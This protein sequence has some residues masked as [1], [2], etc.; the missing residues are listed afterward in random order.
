MQV[1]VKMLCWFSYRQ[2]RVKVLLVV[3]KNVEKPEL[4]FGLFVSRCF[5]SELRCRVLDILIALFAP[6]IGIDIYQLTVYLC[7]R[8]RLKGLVKTKVGRSKVS[9]VISSMGQPEERPDPKKPT[10]Q[11]GGVGV[12]NCES[13]DRIE[14][15]DGA[16]STLWAP[17]QELAARA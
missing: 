3:N 8:R 5:F 10:A 12:W 14:G 9:W 16:Y 7:P 15:R 13:S 11:R 1:N 17:S 2:Q 4:L 6:I